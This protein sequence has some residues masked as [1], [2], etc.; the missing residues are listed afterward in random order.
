MATKKITLASLS[1]L[2]LIILMS[3]S[4][5]FELIP[6]E[7]QIN[8]TAGSTATF[9]FKIENTYAG[10]DE[11]LIN[12]SSIKT[13]LIYLGN[14]INKGN[15]TFGALPT[16]ID[17]GTTSSD[18]SVTVKVPKYT[19]AGIYIGTFD[20]KGDLAAEIPNPD[21]KNF[22]I[23]LN[24]TESKQLSISSSTINQ[25][26]TSTTIV[27]KN[28]G[29]TLLTIN[30]TNLTSSG[31]F[32]LN[33]TEGGNLISP[34]NLNPGDSKNIQVNIKEDLKDLKL[35]ENKATITAIANDGTTASGTITTIKPYYSGE[36]PGKLRITIDEVSVEN[37]FGWKDDY[38][39]LFDEISMRLEVENNWDWDMRNIKVEWELYS[40]NGRK[41]SG[42]DESSFHL[43]SNSEKI[44]NVNFKLNERINR[45]EGEDLVFYVKAVGTIR[46]SDAGDNDG[47]ETGTWKSLNINL[48]TNEDFLILDNFQFTE[49]TSCGKDLQV[50]FDVWNIGDSNQEKVYIMVYNRELGINQKIEVGDIDAFRKK[51]MDVELSIPR[52]V[53]EKKYFIYFTIYD[54]NN[55]AFKNKNN[56]IAEFP[57]SLEVKG[58]CVTLESQ[59]NIV[60]NL[61]SG[62]QSGKDLVVKATITNTGDSVAIYNLDVSGYHEWATFKSMEPNLIILNSG[63][64][65]EVLIT[66]KVNENVVGDKSFDINIIA[67]DDSKLNQPVSITI[68]ESKGFGFLTGNVISENNFYL[69][70]IGALNIILV[71][72]IILVALKVAKK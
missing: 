68:R 67:E 55:N 53:E 54:R 50:Y 18:I 46:D 41:I 17:A 1:I 35:G 59:V 22:T 6:S 61:K 62:G 32:S 14:I 10:V 20:I 23:K 72:I 42:G 63:E 26:D 24:V 5:A 28:E 65:K 38:W 57:I 19:Q 45:L 71:I 15:I 60:A 36:N 37:G 43:K 25:G 21:S 69:W 27:I 7:T 16:Q 30:P 33:F 11:H 47:K 34:F 51:T 8:A 44:V 4:S 49:L 64:S 40:T 3:F 52:V 2:T 56:D 13:D 58:N 31:D 9:T 70:G 66:L 29:N 39:Y 12:L 48:I